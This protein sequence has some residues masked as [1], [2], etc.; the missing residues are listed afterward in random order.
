MKL[1]RTLAAG[2]LVAVLV[3]LQ[4]GVASATVSAVTAAAVPA[5]DGAGLT[6]S[7]TPGEA[8]RAERVRVESS[9]WPARTQVQAVVCGDLA[10]GGSAACDQTTGVLGL[11]DV[12]GKVELDLVVGNPP[13]PC[14]C[15][16]R[17]ASYTGPALAVD[18]PFVITGHPVGTPPTPTIPMPNLAISDVSLEGGGGLGATIGALFGLAPART[19]VVTVR[20]EGTA[21]AVNPPVKI[22]VEKSERAKPSV[23]DGRDLTIEPL[24]T[25]TV[26]TSVTLPVFA[27][28]TYHVVGAVGEGEVAAPFA[29]TW[30]A[31]PWGLIA[32]YVPLLILLVWG[33]RRRLA[34]RRERQARVGDPAQAASLLERPYPL[35]D[36]VYV[37]AVGGFLVSPKAV[38][39]TGLIKQLDGRLARGDLEGLLHD[40]T[41]VLSA[42]AVQG[43]GPGGTPGDPGA[44][45][46]DLRALD[47]WLTRQHPC[48]PAHDAGGA[49]ETDGAARTADA[50]VDVAAADAWLDRREH[51][52]SSQAT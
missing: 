50:I 19:L 13:R 41:A 25:A 10:I 22:G 14:P 35:P 37:D 8:G 15:V 48:A 33:I 46:V 34:A 17:I 40:P 36:V 28:G 39:K 5:A 38:G 16:V 11:S 44:A 20:N 18:T 43:L 31:Y 1:F 6:A 9:G 12:D 32:L 24:Q 42:E 52:R 45:V 21:A 23:V 27:F 26:K 30:T 47:A 49:G 2:L 3:V 4:V 7:V 29:T 51:M